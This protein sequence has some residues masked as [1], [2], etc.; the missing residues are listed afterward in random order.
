MSQTKQQEKRRPRSRHQHKAGISDRHKHYFHRSDCSA[1]R[2]ACDQWGQRN[3]VDMSAS[4]IL[5][6]RYL[7]F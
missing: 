7:G 1:I 4:H 5:V 3:N 2:L 6:D